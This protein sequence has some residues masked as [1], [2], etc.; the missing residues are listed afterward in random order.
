MAMPSASYFGHQNLCIID[1][2]DENYGEIQPE[3]VIKDHEEESCIVE[4]VSDPTDIA[5][6]LTVKVEVTDELTTNVELK[7]IVNGSVEEPIH[8]LAIVEKV[9]IE[10][11]EEFHSF[12]F[13]N[14]SKARA[15]EISYD[16]EGRKLKVIIPQKMIWGWLVMW[17]LRRSK[18]RRHH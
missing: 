16:M 2:H 12:S 7:P 13:D 18:I 9:P 6:N 5:T 15:T 14:G 1:D 4:L 11:F 8:F 3:L 10:E 17:M